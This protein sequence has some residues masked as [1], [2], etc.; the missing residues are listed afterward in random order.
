MTTNNVLQLHQRLQL[1][2][3]SSSTGKND[4][5]L[6]ELENAVVMAQNMLMKITSRYSID[7][8]KY[9]DSLKLELLYLAEMVHP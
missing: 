7:V 1:R 6:K 3:E 8:E 4:F 5:M 2:E 9:V